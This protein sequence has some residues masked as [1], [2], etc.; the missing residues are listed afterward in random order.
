[1]ITDENLE[2]LK[3]FHDEV[4]RVAGRLFRIHEART[5]CS[6]GCSGCCI[7]DLA[8]FEIEAERIRR[9]A[10]DLLATGRPHP[11]GR[12][13][14]LSD[15]GACR[16]YSVRP[17]VCRTQGLPLRWIGETGDGS[18]S[19]MRDICELNEPGPPIDELS[20]RDC[21][22]LGP[23]EDRLASL[24]AKLDGGRGRRVKLRDL[25]AVRTRGI[26]RG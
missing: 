25:F 4:D 5:R 19:E 2:E 22:T 12:C 18:L 7:D 3:A 14:F 9:E 24:Q 11:T 16:I 20:R 21:W 17:Y 26:G 13:A 10:A 1:M 15:D 8:V 23:F 6:R